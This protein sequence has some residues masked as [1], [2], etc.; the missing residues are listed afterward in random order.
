[1]STRVTLYDVL[2]VKQDATEDEIRA[3]FRKLTIKYHPD[4]YPPDRRADA[5]AR[6][7][8]ITEAF[9]VLGH[10]AS[11]DRYDKELSLGTDES[12]KRDPREIAQRLAAKGAQ[13]F[14]NGN[15]VEAREHLELAIHHD[16]TNSRAHYFLGMTLLRLPDQQGPAL[17][18]LDRAVQLEPDNLAM[19]VETA[20]AFEASGMALR[21]RRLAADVLSVDPTNQ[22]AGEILARLD[23]KGKQPSQSEG[24]LLGRMKRRG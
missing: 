16:E 2:G 14:K 6:F 21:A 8:E 23:E 5:E 1:M 18:H 7:Q 15:L 20:R 10:P 17:R 4:R 24:G 12:K 13:E 3:A 11:R 19:K 22:R 9:N